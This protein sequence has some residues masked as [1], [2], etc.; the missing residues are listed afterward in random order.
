MQRRPEEASD[1]L[2]AAIAEAEQIDR[3]RRNTDSW[4]LMLS[5]LH[6]E[7]GNIYERM[8]EPDLELELEQLFRARDHQSQIRDR[9]V[10]DSRA[11]D[12]PPPDRPFDG[13]AR[14]RFP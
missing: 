3:D 7:L 10:L 6:R 11:R 5:S 9:S 14:Q 2:L 4:H 8:E 13:P 1:E 12:R